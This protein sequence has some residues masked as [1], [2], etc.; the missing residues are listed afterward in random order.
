M[1]QIEP[2]ESR[3]EKVKKKKEFDIVPVLTVLYLLGM[4]LMWFSMNP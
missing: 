3:K 2:K 1:Y 4:G